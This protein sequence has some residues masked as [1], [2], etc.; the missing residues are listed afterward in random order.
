MRQ[1]APRRRYRPFTMLVLLAMIAAAILYL[2]C[3]EGL[4][5]GPGG[6]GGGGTADGDRVDTGD[7]SG[8][9]GD[10]EKAKAE[11]SGSG[12][13]RPAV[14]SGTGGRPCRLRLDAS[15]LTLDDRPSTVEKAATACKEAGGAELTVIGDAISGEFKRVRAALEREGVEVVVR[16]PGNVL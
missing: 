11:E 2:R 3:G 15:G 10:A 14:G 12:D 4:G 13:V 9:K 8:A 7:E 5:L 1:R 6:G 16:D